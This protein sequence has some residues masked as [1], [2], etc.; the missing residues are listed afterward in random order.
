M[1]RRVSDGEEGVRQE[2]QE[3]GE[4]RQSG[5]KAA[6]R[7]GACEWQSAG[8][9]EVPSVGR[10]VVEAVLTRVKAVRRA[11]LPAV[12]RPALGG[13]AARRVAHRGGRA[14]VAALVLTLA[15]LSNRAPASVVVAKDFAALCDEADLIFVGTVTGIESRWSDPSK[16]AIETLVT[17]GSLTWLRGAPQSF[18]TL[19]FGG[20]DMDGL[21]EEIAGV[22]HFTL[23]EKRVIFAHDGTYVSPIVGFDQGALRIVDDAGAAAV[24][25]AQSSAGAR[26]ALRLGTPTSEA[27]SPVPLDEFLDRVRR[28][29]AGS[30][31]TP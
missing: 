20:G 7:C 1:A 15:L 2:E 17:F 14:G 10:P 16:Q 9:G 30:G 4:A 12:P 22:P 21:R 25:G 31:S 8:E 13:G 24:V 23:G 5:G 29:L 6:A 28:Q 19:R 26:G 27:A 3:V 18:V 11:V